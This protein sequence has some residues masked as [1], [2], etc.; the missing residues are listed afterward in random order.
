MRARN[1]SVAAAFAAPLLLLVACGSDPQTTAGDAER[2]S[3]TQTTQSSA[4]ATAP[5]GATASG[6]AEPAP[7]LGGNITDIT[8]VHGAKVRQASTTSPD[9]NNPRGAC[10]KVNFTDL[11]ENFQWFRMVFDGQEV[12][13]QLVLIAA[14]N[15]AP[16]DGTICFAPVKGFTVGHHI[17]GIAV[18]SPRDPNATTRQIVQWSFDVIP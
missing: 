16:K 14:S 18:Q 8:P 11:P 13:S 17:A 6:S 4:V 1:I 9:P 5:T 10:A 7:V 12:T 2:L 15:N 3:R